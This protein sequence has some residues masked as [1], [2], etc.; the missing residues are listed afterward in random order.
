MIRITR[1]LY[2]HWGIL[3]LF[4]LSIYTGGICTLLL[5]YAVVAVHEMFHVL[6]A[7]LMQERIGCI[8]VQPFGMTLRLRAGIV[9]EPMKEIVIA[10]AG[11]LANVLMLV[12]GYLLV[13]L[14]GADNL[15]LISFC[16]ANW[17]VL[18]LNLLPCLPLDGG[19]VVKALLVRSLGYL[20]AVSVM[21]R[22]SFFITTLLAVIGVLLLVITRFNIS[23]LLV[24]AFLTFRM[25]EERKENEY[26]FM[27]E[28]LYAKDKLQR[29]KH[30]LAKTISVL[31]W[32]RAQDVFKMLSYDRFYI[33]YIVNE[34]QQIL[35]AVTE[36]QLVDAVL[37]K[38]WQISIAEVF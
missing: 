25:T 31:E 35:R 12:A 14:Y 18:L 27:R 26:V 6:A 11:P 10:L 19:R 15:S 17:L 28:I 23:L 20:S 4:F 32:V 37:E 21:K 36:T 16:F 1:F 24:A 9:R 8:I 33:I 30:L 7:V 13:P 29:K 34:K 3:P 22:I 38:G 2:I 5:S